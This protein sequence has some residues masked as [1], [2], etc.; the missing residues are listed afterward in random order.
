MKDNQKTDV[1][2]WEGTNKENQKQHGEIS[3]TSI[4]LAKSML[5][6]QGIIQMHVRKKRKSLGRFFKK[7]I[8]SVD[9]T[10][11]TKQLSSMLATGV[12][13]I[14]SF[15]IIIDGV[16]NEHM[17]YLATHLKKDIEEGASFSEALKKHPQYFDELYCNLIAI[18]EQTGALEILLERIA[19]YKEKTEF[20]KARVK[21]VMS[22]PIAILVVACS[23][24]A[25]LLVKVV[26]QFED[27]FK[28]FGAELPLL[29]QWIIMMS[30]FLQE[31]WYIIL[32]GIIGMIMLGKYWLKTSE[33]LRYARDKFLLNLPI[34][35]TILEKSSVA[36]FTRTLA[37]TFA[38]GLPLTDALVSIS[39][40]MNNLIY[41]EA[42]EQIKMEVSAGQS[43]QVAMRNA[44]HF[45]NM[46]IQ[47]ISIGE[48][49]G[50]LDV[51]LNKIAIYYEQEVDNLVDSLMSL[52]EPII[53]S[54][55]GI[56][57]GGLVIAMYLPIFKLGGAV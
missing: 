21:K 42:A 48:E 13:L 1:F 51:M 22:Y 44:G 4:V 56:L 16:D 57:V 5:R 24:S 54:V 15:E 6:K 18:G 20:L 17:K 35:G 28:G 34:I 39:F 40:S 41:K 23:I 31:V 53:M 3:A 12:P 43:L 11:F 37:T 8:K 9:I 25:L 32:C 36:R 52:L 50:S 19:L 33:S 38:A 30:K 46:S 10:L 49:S 27:V 29:T 55:L 47:M 2:I 14:R 45:P 26:P 7:K